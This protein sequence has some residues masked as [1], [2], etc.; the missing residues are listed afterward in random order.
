[1]ADLLATLVT[2][3]CATN[4]LS[5]N[6]SRLI[7]TYVS[8]APLSAESALYSSLFLGGMLGR[9]LIAVG[10]TCVDAERTRR[11]RF[12]ERGVALRQR[13]T[14]G[15]RSIAR[16]LV[17]DVNRGAEATHGGIGLGDV[18]CCGE[19]LACGS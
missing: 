1:M 5:A 14:A 17:S 13:K 6:C 7:F 4:P 18:H 11:F 16:P 3:S 8:A 19:E 10:E 2:A 9:R 12:N 15:N